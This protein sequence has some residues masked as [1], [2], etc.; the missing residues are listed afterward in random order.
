MGAGV[1]GEQVASEW[2]KRATHRGYYPCCT[3]LLLYCLLLHYQIW[4]FEYLGGPI[5]GREG[6]RKHAHPPFWAAT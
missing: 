2:S 6:S 1:I 5:F 4:T 3:V